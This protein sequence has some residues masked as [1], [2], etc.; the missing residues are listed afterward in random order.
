MYAQHL[1]RYTR[2]K[3]GHATGQ[4][5]SLHFMLSICGSFRGRSFPNLLSLFMR[6]LFLVSRSSSSVLQKA[7]L[8]QDS[9]CFRPNAVPTF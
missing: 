3:F 9:G 6:L 1:G 4:A 8:I 5:E 2:Q 7:Q